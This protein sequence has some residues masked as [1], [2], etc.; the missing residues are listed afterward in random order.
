MN[1]IRRSIQRSEG[2]EK[3]RQVKREV[4]IEKIGGKEMTCTKKRQENDKY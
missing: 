1:E 3:K 4:E 2:V